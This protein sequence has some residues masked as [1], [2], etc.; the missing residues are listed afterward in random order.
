MGVATLKATG[1]LCGTVGKAWVK[2]RKRDPY[3]RRAKAEGYRSRAAY[4]LIQINERFNIIRPGFVVVDLGAAPG[5]WS[6]VARK[7]VGARGRVVAV[8]LVPMAALED[9]TFI[10]GDITEEE[11][12]RRLLEL[13]PGGVDVVISDMSPRLSGN[14]S[15]DHAR[16]IDLA[17]AAFGF[18]RKTLKPGGNLAVKVFQGDMYDDFRRRVS[19]HFRTCRGFTPRA[20]LKESAEIYIVAKGWEGSSGGPAEGL[21]S[22]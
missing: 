12:L 16:S 10:R 21:K 18:A 2:A 5:G 22:D 1:G 13:V 17:E 11:T 9:V 3:Y 6:Q 15:L 20:S 14:R 19:G 4:K 8:D 7:L